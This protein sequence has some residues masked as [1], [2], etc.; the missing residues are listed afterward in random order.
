MSRKGRDFEEMIAFLERSLDSAGIEVKSPDYIRGK[1]SGSMREI[2]ATI[3]D[4]IGSAELLVIVECRD[5]QGI[6]DVTWIEQ[7]PKKATDVGASKVIAVSSTGFSPGAKN[8]AASNN[9]DLR[10][11]AEVNP[12]EILLWFGF[13]EIPIAKRVFDIIHVTMNFDPQ[14]TVPVMFPQEV[15]ASLFPV[16]DTQAPIFCWK[17][18]GTQ[19]CFMDIWNRLPN[20]SIYKDV[21]TDGSKIR[22]AVT[23]RTPDSNSLQI[24]T[25]KGLQEVV[26]FHVEVDLWTDM[27]ISPLTAVREYRND[28][29]VLAHTAGFEFRVGEKDFVLNFRTW[30]QTQV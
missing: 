28:K 20:D 7:L 10:T 26:F 22:K 29:S 13:A 17:E 8:V 4:K 5:R 15:E 9:I 14:E 6:Q 19:I 23:I 16:F 21:P 1:N 24:M 3:R 27:E 2:D 18:E 25:A 30:P 12:N 11:Y